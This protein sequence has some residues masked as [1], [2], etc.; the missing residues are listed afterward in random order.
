MYQFFLRAV[1]LQDSQF[2]N[3]SDALAAFYHAHKGFHAAQMVGQLA[4]TGCLQLAET[5]QL[6]AKTMP[7][8]QQPKLFSRQVRSPYDFIAEKTVLPRNIRVELFVE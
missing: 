4:G 6:V 5:L 2:G 8:I 3:E 7:F 1:Q